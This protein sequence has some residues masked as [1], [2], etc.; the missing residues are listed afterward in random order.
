MFCR[1]QASPVSSEEANAPSKKKKQ[2]K[3]KQTKQNKTPNRIIPNFLQI[4][5]ITSITKITAVNLCIPHGI[6]SFLALFICPPFIRL[7]NS[8]VCP[9]L[10]STT[11]V[12]SSRLL[13]P[14]CSVREGF[15][16]LGS[17]CCRR[18]ISNSGLTQL[19]CMQEFICVL[20]S[21]ILIL[22]HHLHRKCEFNPFPTP[23]SVA[24]LHGAHFVHVDA[25]VS[26]L[27]FLFWLGHPQYSLIF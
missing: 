14:D 21:L 8:L 1:P 26:S 22:Y 13:C 20:S 18:N 9:R 11:R 15:Y 10:S 5:S 3:N 24:N 16:T 12:V 25:K 27:V 19:L 4:P 17:N 6:H 23:S 2:R 7:S